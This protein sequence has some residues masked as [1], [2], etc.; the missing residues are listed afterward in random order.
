MSGGLR[1]RV[2][3]IAFDIKVDH[4]SPHDLRRT[5]RTMLAEAGVQFHTA[6]RC[7]GHSL[8]KLAETYDRMLIARAVAVPKAESEELTISLKRAA[9]VEP[10]TLS[11]QFLDD[12]GK[13]AAE[14]QLRLIV[15]TAPPAS[16]EDNKYNWVLVKNG[17]LGRKSYVESGPVA[18]RFGR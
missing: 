15:S 3:R 17:Q 8:G 13:P 16:A 12:A 1:R 7:I 9:T 10:F 14:A 2:A 5:F 4:F 6:E 11:G 18:H